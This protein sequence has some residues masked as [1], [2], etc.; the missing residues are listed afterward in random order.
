MLGLEKPVAL[1]LLAVIFSV[2][3]ISLDSTLAQYESLNIGLKP[4]E[5]I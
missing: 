4:C 5:K 3:V 2:A 1:V